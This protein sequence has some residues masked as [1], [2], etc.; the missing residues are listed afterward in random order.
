MSRTI[1]KK[2]GGGSRKVR[3]FLLLGSLLTA[4]LILIVSTVGN[5]E[6]GPSHK[7]FLELLGPAQSVMMQLSAYGR[8]RVE[9]FASLIGVREENKRLREQLKEA[10]ELNN[11][12]REAVATNIRLRK[13]LEFKESLPL[14]TLTARI[15]GK[16]PSLW[17]RTIIVD[18][19]SSD[20][21]EKGMP[22]ATDEGIVGQVLTTSP[23]YAKVLLA[24]DP[25]SAID[26]LL[27]RT[28]IRGILK[29]MGANSYQLHYV[30][31][32]ADVVKGDRIVTS[33]LGGAFPQGL[34]VGTV[35][36][37]IA[38]QRGMFQEIEVAP[39]T[40]FSLLE[41]VIIIMKRTSLT[42]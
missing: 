33:E 8:G 5:Q 37:V 6:F 17:F 30:L 27:Q 29:G 19:G 23:N 35:S 32:N 40:D 36:K 25:N 41:N 2:Q 11:E 4:L 42:D 26:V 13:Q 22:V 15:I 9:D 12:Y 3:F 38:D 24:T 39:A 21:I 14:P 31:K 7:F 10:R 1:R 28:R 18:R 16:D 34:L 20:G